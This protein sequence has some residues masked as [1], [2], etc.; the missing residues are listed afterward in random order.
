MTKDT[1]VFIVAIIWLVTLGV[2]IAAVDMS[3][4]RLQVVRGIIDILA[5]A[6]GVSGRV[7]VPAAAR[8]V[9]RWVAAKWEK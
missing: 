1:I 5:V 3:P 9:T 4:E 7:V 6:L 2:V 8:R